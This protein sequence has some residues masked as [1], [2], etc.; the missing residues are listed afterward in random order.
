[1]LL[2]NPVYIYVANT[3]IMTRLVLPYS[4]CISKAG[5]CEMATIYVQVAICRKC[6]SGI[7]SLCE[8]TQI[9]VCMCCTI[10]DGLA[11]IS[12]RMDLL[13]SLNG[14][15]TTSILGLVVPAGLDL[16]ADSDTSKWR[17]AKNWLLINLGVMGFLIG[18][19]VSIQ[20]FL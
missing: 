12:K 2:N 18:T 3:I 8:S 16:L 19:I 5:A 14:A 10:A 20:G 11:A 7:F 4:S 1:M 15:L 13:V 6:I 17:Q 9:N